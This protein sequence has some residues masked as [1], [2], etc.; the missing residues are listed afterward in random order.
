VELEG[1]FTDDELGETESVLRKLLRVREV[2]LR[3]NEAYIHSAGQSDEYR[4]EPPFKLQGSNRNMNRLASKVQAVMNAAEVETLIL[5]EYE[6]EAQTLTTG[7]EANLLKFKELI[8]TLAG[9]DAERWAEIKSTFARNQISHGV[10][11]G[12]PVGQAVA[13]LAHLGQGVQG[14]RDALRQQTVPKAPPGAV[15]AGLTERTL[16]RLAGIVRQSAVAHGVLRECRDLLGDAVVRHETLVER[17]RR[18]RDQFLVP[19]RQQCEGQ[20]IT[21]PVDTSDLEAIIAEVETILREVGDAKPA[22][23]VTAHHGEGHDQRSSAT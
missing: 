23:P 6:N 21:K 4:T 9:A 16:D 10:D 13:Q 8:G 5:S 1:R 22:A 17:C 11:A 2:V 12:D 14:I 18:W 15:E 20:E 3:V 19:L 7:A